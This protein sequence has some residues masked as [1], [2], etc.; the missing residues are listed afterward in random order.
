MRESTLT[1]RDSF[2]EYWE[3]RA[4][5]Y[6]SEGDGLGAVCSYGMP[7]FYNRAIE[8]TQWLALRPW[9]SV[10]RDTSVLDAGCGIGRWSR[11]LAGRGAQ[12]TGVD[13]SP[14]MIAQAT[15]RAAS[16]GVAERCRFLAA[17]LPDLELGQRFDLVLCVTVLQHILDPERHRRALDRLRAH[18]STKGRLVLLEVAPVSPIHRCDTRTFRA[19]TV[20]TYRRL[21]DELGLELERMTGVDTAPLKALV[22]PAYARLP[23]PLAYLTLATATAVTFPI[24]AALGRRLVDRSWHKVMVLR[25]AQDPA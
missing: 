19:I 23:R 2:A 20:D 17:D 18:L 22:L 21:F 6:A 14:T 25:H 1:T 8:L 10:A 15:L 12:V 5:R 7:G 13:V 3:Q 11:I 9:L 16:Q 24:D 4:R